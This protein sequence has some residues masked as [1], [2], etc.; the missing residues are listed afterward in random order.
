MRDRTGGRRGGVARYLRLPRSASR[1]RD[2]IDEELRF[3]IEIRA[4]DLR[5][6]GVSA[7]EAE[8]RASREFGD[9][10]GTRR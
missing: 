8:R 6:L 3:D 9:L 2:D 10:D 4:R 5:A 1:I 7:E